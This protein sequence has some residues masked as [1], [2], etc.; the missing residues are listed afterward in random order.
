MTKIG[1]KKDLEKLIAQGK[2]KGYLTYD[3]VNSIISDGVVS[4]GEID[5]IFLE[6]ENKDIRIL[7]GNSSSSD[8]SKRNGNRAGA[9]GK[10]DKVSDKLPPLDDPVKM[11]LKQMGSISLLSREEEIALAMKIEEAEERFIETVLSTDYARDEV[12]KIV[13]QIIAGELNI[14]EFIKD[15]S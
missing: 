11:Y 5:K 6:L 1:M 9:K 2:K 7:N 14:E 15:H 13:D 8:K 3:E 10:E 4:S 12:L